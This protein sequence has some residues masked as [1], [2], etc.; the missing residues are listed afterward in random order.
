MEDKISGLFAPNWQVPPPKPP[1]AMSATCED[2][3][4]NDEM[5]SCLSVEPTAT[6]VE[7]QPGAEIALVKPLLPA[8]IAVATPTLLRLSMLALRLSVSQ[9]LVNWPPPRL[10]LAAASEPPAAGARAFG[11]SQFSAEI[12][13][14]VKASTHG[15]LA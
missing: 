11:T 13:S 12:W 4:L 3:L 14:L 5:T 10:I 9:A 15:A 1:G 2:M 7:M 8:A 6:A